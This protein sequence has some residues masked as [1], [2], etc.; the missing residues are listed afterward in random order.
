ML[1]VIFNIRKY[2]IKEE[3]ETQLQGKSNPETDFNFELSGY[4]E[5]NSMHNPT[6][7]ED[8]KIDQG[9][10]H[11]LHVIYGHYWN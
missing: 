3:N 1:Y 2:I 7:C 6:Q 11:L 4:F 9:F 8:V 5:F 10:F